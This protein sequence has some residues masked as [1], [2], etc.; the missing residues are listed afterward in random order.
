MKTYSPLQ[1][2]FVICQEMLLESKEF[3]FS[4]LFFLLGVK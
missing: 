3:F 4:F 2:W 1:V